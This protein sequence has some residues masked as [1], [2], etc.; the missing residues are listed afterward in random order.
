MIRNLIAI[1]TMLLTVVLGGASALAQAPAQPAPQ[2]QAAPAPAPASEASSASYVLGPNDEIEISVFGQTDLGVKTRIKADGTIIVPFLGTMTAAQRTPAQLSAQ[3]AAAYTQGG[4]LTKPSINVEV[5]AYASKTATVLGNVPNAG[6]YPLDRAYSVAEMVAKAGGVRPDGA[7]AVILTPAGGTE[8][9]LSLMDV[10]AASS[11]MVQPGD[12]LFVPPAEMVYVYG[13][14]NT[15]GAYPYINGMTF[16]QAMAKA[17]GPTLAGSTRKVEV[18]REGKKVKVLLDDPAQP[19][20]VLVIKEK[21][22]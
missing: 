9:R 14:V 4:Y 2:V 1:M 15:P 8:M 5:T 22:F 10:R 6:L 20:D 16:R 3:I 19:E 7:N 12:T 18:R 21:L 17:G 11:R 13:Q